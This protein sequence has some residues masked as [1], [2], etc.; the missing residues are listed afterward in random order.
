MLAGYWR[1]NLS[2]IS[3]CRPKK[4]IPFNRIKNLLSHKTYVVALH[5]YQITILPDNLNEE[6]PININLFAALRIFPSIVSQII[7]TVVTGLF[8]YTIWYDLY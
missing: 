1:L 2:V 6:S 5:V 3:S 7:K 4:G 8:L